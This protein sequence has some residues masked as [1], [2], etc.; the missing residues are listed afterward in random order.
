MPTDRRRIAST[1]WS[2][3]PV[4]P[5]AT[6]CS[7]SHAGRPRFRSP[8]V[9]IQGPPACPPSGGAS[10]TRWRIRQAHPIA[11]TPSVCGVSPTVSSVSSPTQPWWSPSRP[12]L[13]EREGVV[14]FGSFNNL[15]KLADDVLAAW[16]RLLAGVDGSRLLLKSRALTD[17][18]PRAVAAGVRAPRDRAAAPE[19]APYA[20]TTRDHLA[21]YARSIWHSTPFPTTER[22]P[23]A[24][25]SGWGSRC[26]AWPDRPTPGG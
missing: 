1:S 22:P 5:R 24:R 16:A 20:A 15:S 26:S 19:F 14:T 6:A 10:P 8:T 2:I 17:E 18:E 11:S 13:G 7:P 21:L 4:T 3:S 12:L 23:P 25:R 9:D